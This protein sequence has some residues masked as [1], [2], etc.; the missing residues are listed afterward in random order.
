MEKNNTLYGKSMATNFPALSHSMN[1]ADFSNAMGNLMRKPMYF[2]CAE[3]YHK[4]EI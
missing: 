1:F 2:L 3:V 4:T